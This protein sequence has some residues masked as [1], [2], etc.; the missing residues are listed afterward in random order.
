MAEVTSG[1][2]LTVIVLNEAEAHALAAL[3]HR[4]AGDDRIDGDS[5]LYEL[6]EAMVPADEEW[7]SC[8]DCSDFPVPFYPIGGA[9]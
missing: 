3:L 8:G 4:H 9:A 6:Y 1:T 7:C 2:D 5:R